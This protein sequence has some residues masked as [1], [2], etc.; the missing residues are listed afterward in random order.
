MPMPGPN[1]KFCI[2]SS[3]IAEVRVILRLVSM[4]TTLSLTFDAMSATVFSASARTPP[5]V[6]DVNDVVLVVVCTGV[7]SFGC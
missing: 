4:L 6:L 1:M 5:G 7:D 2:G 3:D